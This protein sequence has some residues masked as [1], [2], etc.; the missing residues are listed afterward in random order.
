M[1]F[2]PIFDV[3]TGRVFAQEALVRGKDGRSAGEIFQKVTDENRYRFDQLCRTTAIEVATRLGL[4]DGLSINF[5][6]N[7]VYEPLHCISHTLWTADKYDF[8]V[9][10]IIFEFTETELVRDVS[11]LKTIIETYKEI[12]FRTAIDDFGAGFSGLNLLADVVPDLIKLD[13]H[14]I[15]GLHRDAVRRAIVARTKQL[16][17]D[18]GVVV[19]A[20]GV[21]TADELDALREL[22]ITLVQGYYLCRPQ[23]EQIVSR[24]SYLQR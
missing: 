8:D 9:S 7:A 3:E 1:A 17:D 6:P 20:E 12:G 23:F 24:P 19:I 5:M 4:E 2:Q 15:T 16:C 13:R 10:R 21:E 14:L 11:H 22:G 18:L